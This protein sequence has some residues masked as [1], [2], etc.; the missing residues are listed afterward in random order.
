MVQKKNYLPNHRVNDS[1]SRLRVFDLDSGAYLGWLGS[2]GPY[3]TLWATVTKEEE[4]MVW[5]E[6]VTAM[7]GENHILLHDSELA[8]PTKLGIGLNQYADWGLVYGAPVLL[9]PNKTIALQ[10]GTSQQQDEATSACLYVYEKSGTRYLCWERYDEFS[11]K[12][13]PETRYT[14]PFGDTEVLPRQKLVYFEFESTALPIGKIICLRAFNGNLVR[15]M[16]MGPQP[17]ESKALVAFDRGLGGQSADSFWKF[18]VVDAG[19]GR[20]ALKTLAD[21]LNLYATVQELPNKEETHRL[22]AISDKIG[23]PQT[24]EWVELGAGKVALKSLANKRYVT[25]N[26]YT[27][28]NGDHASTLKA[29]AAAVHERETFEYIVLSEGQRPPTPG[30]A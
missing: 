11:M 7:T 5:C 29:V 4:D 30:N 6:Y 8:L 14:S 9:L 17:R 13:L 28:R 15:P 10:Q 23:L 27:E 24:F 18:Q 19:H 16:S 26:Q 21:N 3:P 12:R 22:S 1:C 20:V 25:V 2:W